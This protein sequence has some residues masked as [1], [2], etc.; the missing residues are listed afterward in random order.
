MAVG[1]TPMQPGLLS[2]TVSFVEGR[3]APNSIYAV[4]HRKTQSAGA[5]GGRFSKDVFTIDLE[6][7]R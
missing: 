3:L 1:Q 7:G 2:S 6:A 4:L 5:S